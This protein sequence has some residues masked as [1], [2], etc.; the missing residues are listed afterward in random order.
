[1]VAVEGQEVVEC[2]RCETPWEVDERQANRRNRIIDTLEGRTFTAAS[3]HEVLKQCGMNIPAGTIRRWASE[4]T[5]K[6]EEDGGY[7]LSSI[8]DVA[9]KMGREVA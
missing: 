8:I 5:L 3:A 9:A 2:R 4:E 7:R 1:M 6:A